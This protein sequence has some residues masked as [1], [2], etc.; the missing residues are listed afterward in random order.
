MSR[1]VI[2][3][4]PSLP[5]LPTLA[6]EVLSGHLIPGFAPAGDPLALAAL[7][8]YVPTRRA[9][10]GLTSAFAAEL[11][12]QSA[13]LPR[14]RTLGE[15]DERAAFLPTDSASLLP[16]M[17][18][19]HRR[20]LLARLV[21]FWK[22]QLAQATAA[23]LDGEEPQ[24]PAS[25][26][27]AL[28][29]AA[30]LA[31]LLDEATDEGADLAALTMLGLEDRLAGWW[32][33]TLTF[34]SIVTQHWPAELDAL[35]L[36]DAARLRLQWASAQA[37]RYRTNGSP[38]PVIVAGAVT[39]VGPTLELM[40]AVAE[41]P[42]GAVVLAGVDTHLDNESF[43][44]IDRA[45]S[46]AAPGHP[47][48]ATRRMLASL[49]VD[50]HDVLAPQTKPPAGLMHRERFFS[51][52]L[53]PA[54]TTEHW[55]G[56][57]IDAA[58]ALS[59]MA[60]VEA[61]DERQEAL[62]IAIAIRDALSNPDHKVGLAT[63]DRQLARRVVSE[64][65]RFGIAAND[66][67]GQPFTAS[68]PGTLIQLVLS[69]CLAP[70]DPVALIAL[71]KHPLVRLGLQ[72]AETRRGA[73]AIE[74][75]AL[76]GG[77]GSADA[78][79]LANVY[80]Q[81]TERLATGERKSR[82]LQLM[83]AEEQ[84]LGT[85]VCERLA[86]ALEPLLLLRGGA[87]NEV[88][89]YA[90]ALAECL[91]RLAR[92]END[93]L[94]LLYSSEAGDCLA[95]WLRELIAL[96]ETGFAFAPMEWPDVA[97]AL[98]ADQSVAARGGLSARV[99]IWG[100]LEARLQ[101]ID[102]MILGGLNEGTWPQSA[103]GD[104]F[105]SR[106]MR[107]E[108]LLDPPERR[109]GL[110]AHD[111][112]M[113]LGNR[114]LILTRSRR[115]D[116]APAIA[117]RWLQRLLTVAGKDGADGLRAEGDVYLG[118]ARRMDEV[119]ETPRIDRP[120]PRPPLAMRPRRFSVTEVERLI[121]DPYAV[122]ARRILMLEP[123]EPLIRAPG[124]AERGSLYHDVLAAAVLEKLD[125]RQPDALERLLDLARSQFAQAGLPAEVHAV[126]WPR[127]E[128]LAAHYLEWERRRD[129]D[130]AER[131]A[132]LAGE[133][134]LADLGMLL[135]GRADR[136]DRMRDGRVEIIDYKTGSTPSIPQARSLMAPQL[137]LEGAMVQQ[138]AFEAFAA[139][140]GVAELRY[141]RLKEQELIPQALSRQAGRGQEA[142]TTQELCDGALA[143]FRS[144]VALYRNSERGYLSRA[145]PLRAS[146]FNNI[147]DHLARAREW[148]VQT[149]D[150]SAEDEE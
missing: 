25:A 147:Y 38:D 3:I 139:G 66:S 101:N 122:Y 87:Q 20:M 13:I 145:H 110:A 59:G 57:S 23:M 14:I 70:G 114:R 96:P 69:V 27:D 118:Y 131:H 56:Q 121:R 58:Q 2:S 90:R 93:S 81:R 97:A 128:R 44:A 36:A 31:T 150:D 9:V 63:P 125:P 124:A 39:T 12:G 137:P 126:W 73:R 116:G 83:S 49:G 104:T 107:A 29:L 64:L 129:D 1:R 21:R 48:Y 113:S 6:R 89:A 68:P 100:A 148:A 72:A 138:G 18:P 78:A 16:A 82:V 112:W 28:W 46:I 40:R 136:I 53:R 22:E 71:L 62:A 115:R 86:H 15:E 47:Q 140:T 141:I 135:T 52:A 41:M 98:M 37:D 55:A 5:F 143:Q 74:L 134:T 109:I 92:D 4:P 108:I 144:L 67:A 79:E 105:L 51:N 85:Q 30:D 106:L 95:A 120:E 65:E 103:R 45:V 26:A 42:N 142:V 76:R 117:S 24:L 19:L 132:E 88:P 133:L 111:F 7:T 99:F 32:Q 60:L 33:M 123:L 54:E 127:M 91:E 34:L 94:S 10:R 75:I 17:Q 146:E 50:R 119:T 149:E 61:A 80:R 8:I 43:A 130:V 84:D 77:V 35:G 11:G 102:V